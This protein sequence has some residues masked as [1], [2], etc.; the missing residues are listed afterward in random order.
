MVKPRNG[1]TS[2]RAG[3]ATCERLGIHRA[4]I[5]SRLGEPGSLF[6]RYKFLQLELV[7]VTLLTRTR[8]ELL[9]RLA[10]DQRAYIFGGFL[11]PRVTRR[12][13]TSFLFI[14]ASTQPPLSSSNTHSSLY[15]PFILFFFRLLIN[16]P[17]SLASLSPFLSLPFFSS[18]SFPSEAE[19]IGKSRGRNKRTKGKASNDTTK[20]QYSSRCSFAIPSGIIEQLGDLMC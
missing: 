1:E 7:V 16:E 17:L 4:R 9:K 2:E 3:T 11:K 20:G 19:H 6:S 8:R 15:S 13:T 10:N 12:P 5:P 18:V 14:L